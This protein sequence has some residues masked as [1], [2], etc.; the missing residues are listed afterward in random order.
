[1]ILPNPSPLF[2]PGLC[3]V[4]ARFPLWRAD[5][6][7][8]HSVL[9][10]SGTCVPGSAAVAARASISATASA[11]HGGFRPGHSRPQA[12]LSIPG[13]TSIVAVA[14]G[15]GGVGKSTTGTGGLRLWRCFNVCRGVR[16]NR[17]ALTAAIPLSSVFCIVCLPWPE[18]WGGAGFNILNY[19]F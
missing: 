14:S 16:R 19:K 9:P 6:L 1:M 18:G 4:L 15:K 10:G 11:S 17:V 7:V 5:R 2:L 8:R 13:V 12:D 3:S